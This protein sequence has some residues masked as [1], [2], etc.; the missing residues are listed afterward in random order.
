MP[1]RRECGR[2]RRLRIRSRWSGRRG[3]RCG[4]RVRVSGLAATRHRS[5]ERALTIIGGAGISTIGRGGRLATLF[6]C[7]P[8]RDC[9]DLESIAWSPDGRRLAFSVTTVGAVSAYNGLHVY[10]AATGRDRRSASRRVFTGLVAG[11][12]A[13]R[14][15]RVRELPDAVGIDLRHRQRRSHR[16]LVDTGR[17]ALTC[18]LRGRRTASASSSQ[19]PPILPWRGSRAPPSRLSTLTA[20][21]AG[22]SSSTP[23]ARVVPGRSQ[24]RVP[25]Q[26]RRHR[27][28]HPPRA[29]TQPPS[30]PVRM[31]GVDA[32]RRGKPVWSPD[33]RKLAVANALGV[34]VIDLRRRTKDP[35]TRKTRFGSRETGLGIFRTAQPSWRAA[36]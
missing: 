27:A 13:D 5:L 6:R 1:P 2:R 19:P 30:P 33:G 28:R 21:T 18:R 8:S 32:V 22:C 12:L 17:A 34:F 10:D 20:P 15:R 4:E 7:R 11:R 16:R 24:D 26:L 36:P 31:S 9:F 23:A 35:E 25:R 3:A 29:S 14:L